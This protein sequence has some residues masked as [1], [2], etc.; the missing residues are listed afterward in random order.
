MGC[1]LNS[2][3]IGGGQEP[4]ARAKFTLALGP[5]P[6]VTAQPQAADRREVPAMPALRRIDPDPATARL[7]AP[8]P[9]P[10]PASAPV[11][12]APLPV[13]P[14]SPLPRP[15]GGRAE[16]PAARPPVERPAAPRVQA[17]EPRSLARMREADGVLIAAAQRN[18][19]DPL[20]L[21]AVAWVESRHRPEA[22][23]PAGARGLMQVMPQ[24]AA[25]F[26]VQ[27]ESHLHDP[28]LN[29]AAGAA[30]LKWLQGE[31]GND[32]SLV[33]AAYNAGEGAVRR[34]GSRV[35]PY[36]ETTAYVREVLA[37]YRELSAGRAPDGA[38]R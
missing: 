37:A 21:H 6:A 38:R 34:H 28:A 1:A 8:E 15:E 10:E 35:P 33:L 16:P 3:L 32:L 12:P 30:Y 25:R 36:P 31:F 18:D 2:A 23:S 20:L 5:C 17:A 26:G 24:T 9:P 7:L 22:V 19:I 14:A 29:V 27:A 4:S 11:M 13:F